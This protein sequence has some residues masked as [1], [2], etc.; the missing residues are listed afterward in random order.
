MCSMCYYE[1]VCVVCVVQLCS[2]EKFTF[3]KLFQSEPLKSVPSVTSSYLDLEE[4]PTGQRLA[5]GHFSHHVVFD[6]NMASSTL[7][8]QR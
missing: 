7:R 4:S 1:C 8:L 2:V 6:A 3:S 5:L